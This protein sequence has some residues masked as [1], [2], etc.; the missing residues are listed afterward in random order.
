M[1][2]AGARRA[3]ALVAAGIA[4]GF[5]CRGGADAPAADAGVPMVVTASGGAG[6]DGSAPDGGPDA[7]ARLEPRV[8][9]RVPVDACVEPASL[10][11]GAY[12]PAPASAPAK[13]VASLPD[14]DGGTTKVWPAERVALGEPRLRSISNDNALFSLDASVPARWFGMPRLVLVLCGRAVSA[15]GASSDAG[16]VRTSFEIGPALADRAA[17]HLGIPKQLQRPLGER[18]RAAFAAP[19]EQDRSGPVE[20]VF[21]AEN[22]GAEP[23]G[24]RTGGAWRG[25]RD[26]RF[27]F[28]VRRD[29][30]TL[31]DV[32][33]QRSFGGSVEV[34]DIAPGGRHEQR[35]DLRHWVAFTEPGDYDVECRYRVELVAP[36]ADKKGPRAHER[37]EATATQ[38]IR[39]RLR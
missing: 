16:A 18:F 8:A 21:T 35:L 12:A 3:R 5:G 30:V 11:D 26:N 23:L 25:P 10:P 33:S 4:T 20:V 39:L 28:V 22:G 27:G 31:K 9:D 2:A 38:T 32:D 24:M 15:R 17:A 13:L 7:G 6:A 19:G 1:S 36:G 29:G 34:V 37:W 14:A